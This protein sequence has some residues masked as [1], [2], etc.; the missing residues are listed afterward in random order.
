[1]S[2]SLRVKSSIK[3]YIPND[4]YAL[5]YSVYKYLKAILG[6][7]KN[8]LSLIY[9]TKPIFK[10]VSCEGIQ[11][12]LK[13]D[14]NNGSVDK[15]IFLRGVYEPDVL[16][17]IKENITDNSVCLDVGANI[18]QHSLFMA[19]IAKSG[20]VYSFEPLKSL[21]TQIQESIQENK[22]TNIE[23]YNFGVSNSDEKKEIY[24]DN[25]NMGRTTFDPRVEAS[26]KQI[27]EVKVF[28]RFWNKRGKIDFIKMDVEGYEYFALQGMRES[29]ELYHPAILFEFT[30]VFYKKMGIESGEVLL[31]LLSLGYR[32]FDIEKGDLEITQE[33]VLVCVE[34]TPVQTNI[35]CI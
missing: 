20:K 23:V 29:L 16:R 32:L 34:N 26:S 31:Y 10:K 28:D 4:A 19:S 30:P 27:A 2:I 25:L 17:K 3:K 18:G 6:L 1:M 9:F 21:S 5:L 8:Q 14:P 35:L 33:N 24:L 12:S 7:E 13:L 11:F 15:E 22:Y